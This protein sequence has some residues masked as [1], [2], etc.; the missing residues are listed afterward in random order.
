MKIVPAIFSLAFILVLGCNTPPDAEPSNNQLFVYPNPASSDAFIYVHPPEGKSFVVRAFDTKG[1]L[2]LE[3]TDVEEKQYTLP[4]NDKPDGTYQVI[5][6][7]GSS[8]ITQSVIK[9]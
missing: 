9:I 4:L 5:L 2:M 3:E 6:K 1:E 7:V 8:T